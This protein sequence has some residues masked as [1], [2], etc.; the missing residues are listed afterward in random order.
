[1]IC[2]ILGL[3]V[4]VLTADGKYSLLNTEILRQPIH[5][6]LSMDEKTFAQFFSAFSK[7]ELNV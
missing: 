2:K 7:C 3:F 6:Q 4:N 5:M 1:M